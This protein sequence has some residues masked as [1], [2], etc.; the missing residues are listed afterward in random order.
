MD[1][2]GRRRHSTPMNIELFF[3]ALG[4]AVFMEGVFYAACAKKLP[5]MFLF[6]AAQAPSTLRL[7]GIIAMLA[8]LGI[9]ALT[10]L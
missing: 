6:M 8:G 5:G 2:K 4:L 10:R 1:K 9:I 7:G 3:C